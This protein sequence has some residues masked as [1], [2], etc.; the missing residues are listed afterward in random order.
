MQI[1]TQ[2]KSKEGVEKEL[3]VFSSQLSELQYKLF[4][5][6]RHAL[7]IILRPE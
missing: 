7:V 2:I 5:D 6:N 4:A 1:I 3:T